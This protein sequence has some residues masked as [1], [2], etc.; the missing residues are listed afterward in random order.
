MKY[1]IKD[2]ITNE[3]P[4]V[5]LTDTL[6]VTVN[7]SFRKVLAMQEKLRSDEFNSDAEKM[8]SVLECLL[9]K[10]DVKAINDMDLPFD[11]YLAVVKTI[12][13]AA[14]GQSIETVEDRFQQAVN[15]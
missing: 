8:V 10:K 9:D 14:T 13:A 7:N 1:S 3:K 4:T 11:Q 2:K 12:I 15:N 6:T 5:E